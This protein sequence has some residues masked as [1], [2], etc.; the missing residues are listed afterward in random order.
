VGGKSSYRR[1]SEADLAER[2]FYKLRSLT[3][4]INSGALK[5]GSFRKRKIWEHR[6]T[7][8][9]EALGILLTLSLGYLASRRVLDPARDGCASRR[10]PL[11]QIANQ[12]NKKSD[13]ETSKWRQ[14]VL[15]GQAGNKREGSCFLALKG[16]AREFSRKYSAIKTK[17]FQNSTNTH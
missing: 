1:Y 15:L 11:E 8:R 6:S 13:A 9:Q 14:T 17:P 7:G 16:C 5:F 2:S 10:Q 12:R 4:L 3:K